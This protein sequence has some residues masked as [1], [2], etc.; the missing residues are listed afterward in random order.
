MARAVA[1]KTMPA[2]PEGAMCWRRSLRRGSMFHAIDG[3]GRTLCSTRHLDRNASESPSSL[4]DM[5]YW[6]VCPT[7]I[8]K[9]PAEEALDGQLE[10]T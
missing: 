5:Q 7:C 1:P 6:G 4:G 8:K 9:V 3:V 2:V 10:S